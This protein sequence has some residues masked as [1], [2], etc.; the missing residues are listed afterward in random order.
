MEDATKEEKKIAMN[1]II[2]ALWCTQIK[3]LEGEIKR[4]KMPTKTFLTSSKRSIGNVGDNFNPT[5]SSIHLG[6]SSHSTQF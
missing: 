4:L 6:E 5:C 2:V 1:M 3:M